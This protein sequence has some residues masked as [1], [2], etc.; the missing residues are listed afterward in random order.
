MLLYLYEQLLNDQ[1]IFPLSSLVYLI[2]VVTTCNI[3][4]LHS[5]GLRKTKFRDLAT[6][7]LKRCITHLP[8]LRCR[9]DLRSTK[10]PYSD[11]I[12]HFLRA[13][14]GLSFV[15]ECSVESSQHSVCLCT[16][17]DTCTCSVHNKFF[18]SFY[19]TCVC[20]SYSVKCQQLCKRSS[21]V[22]LALKTNS[23]PASYLRGFSAAGLC[24][25]CIFICRRISYVRESPPSV[26]VLAVCLSNVN[27]FVFLQVLC[28]LFSL[29]YCI[30]I[31]QK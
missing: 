23:E 9:L 25:G 24:C 14:V 10:V 2:L 1:V 18:Y 31:L 29:L 12:C 22:R 20:V 4:S 15:S 8:C 5:K 3:L 13:F 30:V 21:N 27:L 19:D 6:V 26:C 28:N 16:F 17:F 7:V 11:R